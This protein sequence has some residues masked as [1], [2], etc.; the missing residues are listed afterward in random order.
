VKASKH[1]TDPFDDM[2]DDEF[3]AHVEKVFTVRPQTVG[4]S[5]RVPR[6]LLARVKREA[7]RAGVPYQTF[8]KGM[9]EAAVSRLERR[10]GRT[11]ARQRRSA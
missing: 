6:A 1:W 3:D 11:K 2:T 4:I 9:L 5:I 10:G 8:M 7:H